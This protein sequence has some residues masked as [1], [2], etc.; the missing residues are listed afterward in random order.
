MNPP[1]QTAAFEAT[2]YRIRLMG[3]TVDLRIGHADSDAEQH[4]LRQ[5]PAERHWVLITADNPGARL[6]PSEAKQRARRDLRTE[7]ARG[8]WHWVPTRH[9][10][11]QHQWPTEYGYCVADLPLQEA[12]RLMQAHG[13]LAVVLWTRGSAPLLRWAQARGG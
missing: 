8:G 7:L 13:Q 3:E 12:D 5:L 11:L 9:Q 10:D 4:L 1:P 6:Q 2:R